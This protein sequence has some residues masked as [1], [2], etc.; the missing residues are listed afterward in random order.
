ML[1]L[2]KTGTRVSYHWLEG[3]RGLCGGRGGGS[4]P[5][6][7]V[8]GVRVSV[9]KGDA[10]T[11]EAQRVHGFVSFGWVMMQ[12]RA[13]RK[14]E[15]EYGTGQLWGLISHAPEAEVGV[16]MEGTDLRSTYPIPRS[17]WRVAINR[18]IV[19]SWSNL[20][21]RDL[22]LEYLPTVRICGGALSADVP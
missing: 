17:H 20:N 12:L 21:P 5:V 4:L 16:N 19:R 10:H 13:S 11:M 1:Q 3:E 6:C 9:E 7:H 8:C 14:A 2:G 22:L 15:V 18:P